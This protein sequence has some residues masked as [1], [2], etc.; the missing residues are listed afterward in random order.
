MATTLKR[1]LSVMDE[2]SSSKKQ[3]TESIDRVEEQRKIFANMRLRR[4]IKENH[5]QDVNQLG[6]FFNSKNFDAPVG[7][8]V[9]KT[10]DKHG[11][12]Q[13]EYTDTSNVLAT[14]GGPQLNVY[15]NEHCGDHLDIM[16]NFNLASNLKENESS[17]SRGLSTFC[18]LYREEDALIAVAGE[19]TNIHIL[20]I[21]K[22][23]EVSV[24][25]GHSKRIIDI[26]A[27]PH[28]DKHIVSVSKDGT[29]C[30]WDVPNERCLVVFQVDC[31]VICF[32]P[33]GKRFISGSSKGE[34]REWVLPEA[35]DACLNADGEHEPL[36][37]DKSNSKLL[38]KM[39]GDNPIDC[40]RFA[41]GKVLSKSINGR[42]EYWDMDSDESIRSFRIKTGECYSRFDVSLDEGYFCVGSSHGRVYI[43]N[44]NTG[45]QLA[46]LSHRRSTKTIRCCAFSRDCKQI[47]CGGEDGFLWRY[48]YV[49]D[50]TLETW[51]NWRK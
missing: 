26:H 24:L 33:D 18:W 31:N 17:D 32:H 10:F 37:I 48:D 7:I 16:S 40:I 47:L 34:F 4:I 19:D 3:Q 39:H 29:V 45:K 50:A 15:D 30:L 28:N 6:F 9:H 42:M 38:K 13:R 8:D 46:E 12:V 36:V 21:A 35:M 23:K 43:Y 49:D 27:H 5:G 22:S 2:S 1:R 20:S 51:K 14:I 25:K 41:Q 44:L 11:S